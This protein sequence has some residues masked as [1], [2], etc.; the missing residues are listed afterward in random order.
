L[1]VG[2][3]VLGYPLARLPAGS[4][5]AVHE[6]GIMRR[7]WVTAV[8]AAATVGPLAA[9]GESAAPLLGREPFARAH[10]LLMVRAEARGGEAKMGDVEVWAEGTRLRA[11]L[12]GPGS[13]ATQIWVDGLA[14]DPIVLGGGKVVEP[15]K[16]TLEH[17]LAMAL[18]AS[19]GA[20]NSKN[21]RIAGHP[22]KVMTEEL[23]GGLTM[24]R[25]IWRGLPLS[26]EVSG[27]G[28]SFNA[29]ATLVEENAVTVADLQPPPGAPAA[30]PSLS[31]TR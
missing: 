24:T 21:D 7:I 28:F 11:L 2:S 1:I 19:P 16:R 12:R 9:V 8:L 26:V 31:A 20:S 18:R 6:G 5:A 3:L 13:A 17:G 30:P 23:A 22:C 29:A 15:K 25:C 27:R 14:S 4:G 10:L